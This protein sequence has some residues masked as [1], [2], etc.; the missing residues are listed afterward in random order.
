[1]RIKGRDS[2][3]DLC[4]YFALFAFRESLLNRKER[5]EGAKGAKGNHVFVRPDFNP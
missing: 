4:D 2:L 3:R 1:M 5:K